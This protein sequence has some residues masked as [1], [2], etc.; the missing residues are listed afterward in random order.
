MSH[1]FLQVNS[2]KTA[3]LVIGAKPLWQEIFPHAPSL[4][5]KFGPNIPDPCHQ[6]INSIQLTEIF[7]AV[8]LNMC[9]GWLTPM[10]SE[11]L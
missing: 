10:H 2:D 8:D 3:I 5:L 4:L 7:T 1:N 11:S 9:T 6:F